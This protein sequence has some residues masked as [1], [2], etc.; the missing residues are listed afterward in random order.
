M[1][2]PGAL[3]GCSYAKPRIIAII[4]IDYRLGKSTY[5]IESEPGRNESGDPL[6]YCFPCCRLWRLFVCLWGTH[7]TETFLR[8]S[9]YADD[10]VGYNKSHQADPLNQPGGFLMSE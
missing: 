3:W 4:R 8:W 6:A 7:N 5:G 2:I 1:R 10:V 9:S